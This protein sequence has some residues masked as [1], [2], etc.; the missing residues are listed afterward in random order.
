MESGWAASGTRR[1][2]RP[3]RR[4]G[5]LRAGLHTAAPGPP[6]GDQD[7][8]AAGGGGGR[9]RPAATSAR[10]RGLRASSRR[11]PAGRP[12]PSVPRPK[13]I[14]VNPSDRWLPKSGT[15]QTF[16]AR[17]NLPAPAVNTVILFPVRFRECNC[18][19]HDLL[20]NILPGDVSERGRPRAS[21]QEVRAL[22]GTR[23]TSRRGPPSATGSLARPRRG[24]RGRPWAPR[25]LVP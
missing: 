1:R 20:E 24:G 23:A 9:R 7:R 21:E 14:R 16:W 25:G 15:W 10:T 19:A 6:G 3:T 8:G 18:H 13:S 11:D 4:P 5:R 2:Q 17:I 12:R 22:S